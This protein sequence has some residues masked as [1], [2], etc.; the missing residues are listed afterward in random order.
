[1]PAAYA[2]P[3]SGYPAGGGP[4]ANT[5]NPPLVHTPIP[6]G[7]IGPPPDL[8]ES[9]NFGSEFDMQNPVSDRARQ[10]TPSNAVWRTAHPSAQKWA[11][12]RHGGSV[13]TPKPGIIALGLMLAGFGAY[14]L[15]IFLPTKRP[16]TAAMKEELSKQAGVD[17]AAWH[18]SEQ[19][20]GAA[21]INAAL[22]VLLGVVIVLRGLMY[23]Q[24]PAG[25]ARR[26]FSKPALMLIF[27]FVLLAVSFGALL[28]SASA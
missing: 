3:G 11:A 2:L 24:Q 23:R 17:Q 19:L 21:N 27:C 16:L 25:H 4:I 28:M 18:F 9:P 22:F 6:P 26:G 7:L 20:I 12:K 15:M 8:N 5:P 10:D 13:R 1:M 14:L